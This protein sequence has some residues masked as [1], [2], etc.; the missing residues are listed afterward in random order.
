MVG[1]RQRHRT[2]PNLKNTIKLVAKIGLISACFE[3][4]IAI[5]MET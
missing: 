1:I 5:A 3:F 4:R 2:N